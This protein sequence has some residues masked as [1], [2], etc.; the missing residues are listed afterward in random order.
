MIIVIPTYNEEKHIVRAI[1]SAKL[2][3]K[4]IY[5][6]DSGSTDKTTFLAKKEKIKVLEVPSEFSFS[7]KMNYIYNYPDFKNNYIFRHDADEFINPKDINLIKKAVLNKVAEG[8]YLQRNLMF[9]GK[10]LNFG[11]LKTYS[12]RIALSGSIHYE[13]TNLDE[14]IF[15]KIKNFRSI[16]LNAN[17]YDDPLITYG[18]WI[19]KHNRYSEYEAK[20]IVNS[21][22]IFTLQK[23][24]R[25][26]IYYSFPPILRV[27]L[28]FLIRYILLLG[29]LD[30][31]HGLLFH[32]SHSL[33]Y[34]LLVDI[35]IITY[36]NK[37]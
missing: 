33:I 26:K 18:E 3:S 35:K 30:K 37:K 27:I 22:N 4:N 2:L 29:F 9:L 32:I 7:K 20:M 10:K 17:I 25:L 12:L 8:F 36:K 31:L 6:V 15:Q 16:N 11:K 23:P 34:R 5:I 24:F 1:K 14:R 13:D 28:F 21:K 19:N